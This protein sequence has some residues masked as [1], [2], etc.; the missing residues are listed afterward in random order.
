MFFSTVCIAIII[1]AVIWLSIRQRMKLS[2]FH[3]R[4]WETLTEGKS[5]PF[6]QAVLNL[7]G[8]AG[9][10]Y[11]SLVMLLD[12]MKFQIPERIQLGH[13]EIEPLAALSITVAVIQPFLINIFKRNR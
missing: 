6:S 12:F 4:S 2:I 5:S 1:L 8:F 10:I 3:E 11:L 7:V 9:G 13:M